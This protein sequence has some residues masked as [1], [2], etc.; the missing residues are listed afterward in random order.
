MRGLVVTARGRDHRG[1][2]AVERRARVAQRALADG[3]EAVDRAQVA[4]LERARDGA[5]ATARLEAPEIVNERDDG[6]AGAAELTI[7]REHGRVTELVL[8]DD[9][10]VREHGRQR[11]EV[12]GHGARARAP[13]QRHDVDDVPARAQPLDEHAVIEEAARHAVEVAGQH[14]GDAH[15]A[16]GRAHGADSK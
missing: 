16:S 15:G 12:R 5:P 7:A 10:G 6:D 9:V 13:R 3:D 14:E 1:D 4:A 8:Q 2:V 11:P